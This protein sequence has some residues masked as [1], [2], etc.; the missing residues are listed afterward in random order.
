MTELMTRGPWLH[1]THLVASSIIEL[2]I[3]YS[4]SVIQR[5]HTKELMIWD[6]WY[7]ELIPKS[8]WFEIRDTESSYQ[9]ALDLISG[10]QRAHNKEL[11]I[12]YPGHRDLISKSSCFII[13][14]TESSYQRAHAP[15]CLWYRELISKSSCF[16][17]RDTESSYQRAHDLISGTQSSYQ[18]ARIH[19]LVLQYTR[20]HTSTTGIIPYHNL[21]YHALPCGCIM[22]NLLYRFVAKYTISYCT[23]V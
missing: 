18:R 8:S 9:R 7:R 11:M 10:T 5:P 3:R 21:F 22:I 23:T 19:E 16:I 17:I 4:W 12:W 13:R 14:D 15:W 1:D 6:T 20:N 2:M